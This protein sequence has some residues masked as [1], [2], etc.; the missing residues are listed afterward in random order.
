MSS[1]TNN[2]ATKGCWTC[3]DRRVK[4]DLGRPSCANCVRLKQVCQGYGVRLSWPKDGD[5]KRAI[6]GAVPAPLQNRHRSTEIELVHTS[7]FDIEM[8]YYLV[9]LRSNGVGEHDVTHPPNLILPSP[10]PAKFMNLNAEEQE[11]LRYFQSTAYLTLATCSTDLPGFRDMLVVMALADHTIASR[12]VLH[13]LLAL[14]SLQRDGPQLQAAQHKTAAVGALGAS[15]QN[16]ILTTVEA[17]QHVAAN[18]LLCTFE[19]YNGSDSHSHWLWYLLGARDVILVADLEPQMF[20]PEIAE[21]VLWTY[22]HDVLSR[23]T[24]RHWHRGSV[25]RS[26]AKEL[27]VEGGWQRDLCGFATKLRLHVS[28]LP[29]ILRFFADVLDALCD[30]AASPATTSTQALQEEIHK[31]ERAIR[32]IPAIVLPPPPP[33]TGPTSSSPETS[34]S[35]TNEDKNLRKL[36]ALTELHR[37]AVLV[38]ISRIC[39]HRFLESRDLQISQLVASAFAQFASLDEGCERLF[40]VFILGC[41]ASTDEQRVAVLDLLRRTEESGRVRPVCCLRRA[42]DSAWIQ[43]DLNADQDVRLD[44]MSKLNVVVSSSPTPPNFV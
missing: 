11:L 33:S 38:Y 17:A 8:Y 37:S 39:A 44:Y 21:L 30:A 35:N 31:A 4:C 24:L 13:A 19:I 5:T 42:L 22:Y 36:A 1:I 40:P 41:E 20:R 12:A 16:G 2:K 6:V 26:L 34:T 14:S 29:R 27:G 18:M 32:E 15:V 28:P 10:M 7:V 3:K 9:D 43:D 25:P 23:F